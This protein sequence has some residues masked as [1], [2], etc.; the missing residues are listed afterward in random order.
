MLDRGKA[1]DQELK[2]ETV[3]WGIDYRPC[4]LFQAHD[5]Q[6]TP[7]VVVAAAVAAS[8]GDATDSKVAVVEN[9]PNEEWAD[10][11]LAVVRER[12][13]GLMVGDEIGPDYSA[14]GVAF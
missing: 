8:F 5:H 14:A 6:E 11:A 2:A 4:Y 9:E 7:V 1:V 13:V 3:S 12:L 10:F